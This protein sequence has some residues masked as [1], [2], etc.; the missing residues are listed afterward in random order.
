[1]V[2]HLSFF[3]LLCLVIKFLNAQILLLNN[4]TLNKTFFLN[5]HTFQNLLNHINFSDYYPFKYYKF[6]NLKL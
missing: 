6:L 2:E 5:S 3:N 4:Y 1:M